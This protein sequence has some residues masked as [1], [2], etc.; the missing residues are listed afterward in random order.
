M[1]FS[2]RGRL[3]Q[4]YVGWAVEIQ[5]LDYVIKEERP[6]KCLR[7]LELKLREELQDEKLKCFFKI[8]DSGEFYV[9]TAQTPELIDYLAEKMVDLS[10]VRLEIKLE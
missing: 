7:T 5:L 2:I 4:V 10:L 3:I 1:N 9:I 8:G 6:L